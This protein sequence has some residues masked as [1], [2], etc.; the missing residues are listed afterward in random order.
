MI[1]EAALPA[2]LH[3]P[4]DQSPRLTARELHDTFWASRGVT[5]V[6]HAG[7]A[8]DSFRYGVYLLINPCGLA[9]FDIDSALNRLNWLS[10][11][12]LCGR[13]RSKFRDQYIVSRAQSLTGRIGLTTDV[14]VA[15]QWHRAEPKRAW[16]DLR[17]SIPQIRRTVQPVVGDYF[18]STKNNHVSSFVGRLAGVWRGRDKAV[19]RALNELQRGVGSATLSN[20]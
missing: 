1:A 13:I 19:D 6:G 10:P 9:L 7:V 4:A 3:G 8:P 15:R 2:E 20:S 14:D 5:V 18:D 11:L 16:R 12:L 17:E